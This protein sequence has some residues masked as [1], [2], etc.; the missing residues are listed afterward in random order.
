MLVFA[1]ESVLSKNQQS[2]SLGSF[3]I[4]PERKSEF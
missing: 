2:Y 4:I 1:F 3:V